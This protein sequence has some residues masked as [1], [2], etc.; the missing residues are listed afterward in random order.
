[1]IVFE[2]EYIEYITGK[3]VGQNDNVASSPKS[4]VSYL[5]GVSRLI[6]QDI[7]PDTISDSNAI[8]EIIILIGGR[9]EESTLANYKTALRHYL[10]F[11][12][13]R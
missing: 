11:L 5:N 8:N 7:A 3:G 1:M 2:K 6:E 4:Y 12:R 9:R 10:R 13:Q